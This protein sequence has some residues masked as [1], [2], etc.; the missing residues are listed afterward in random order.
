M[1]ECEMY[2]IEFSFLFFGNF[3]FAGFGGT[4]GSGWRV[5]LEK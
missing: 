1:S 3:L 5:I 4:H 2:L